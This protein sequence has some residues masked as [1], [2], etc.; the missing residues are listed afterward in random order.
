MHF[1]LLIIH[2]LPYLG[3]TKDFAVVND[4]ALSVSQN[5]REWFRFQQISEK[6]EFNIINQPREGRKLLVLDL[7]HTI[8]H[9][10]SKKEVANDM[11]KR[12]YMDIFL[13]I[14]YHFYDLCFWSQTSWR[15]IEIK[16]TELGMIPNSGYKVCFILDKTR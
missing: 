9:F 8:L 1:L 11:M 14:V 5:T 6:T 16:L 13:S 12:P 3:D 15:W 4:L 10:T 7:D 2:F